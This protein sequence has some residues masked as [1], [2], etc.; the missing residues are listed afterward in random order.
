[1]LVK[2][3]KELYRD[4]M[5]MNYELLASLGKD[6]RRPLFSTIVRHGI[7]TRAAVACGHLPI[8]ALSPYVGRERLYFLH[9][10]T[11]PAL[12]CSSSSPCIHLSIHHPCSTEHVLT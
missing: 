6:S 7:P 4:V 11:L 9:L 5:R 2:R 10:R 8:S 1:M 3:Q 12:G